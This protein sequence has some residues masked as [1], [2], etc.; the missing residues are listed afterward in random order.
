MSKHTVALQNMYSAERLQMVVSSITIK[1]IISNGSLQS[2]LKISNPL[3]RTRIPLTDECWWFNLNDVCLTGGSLNIYFEF[4][5][6]FTAA[7]KSF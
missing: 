4:F 2:L 6:A 5:L 7:L 1:T 3:I